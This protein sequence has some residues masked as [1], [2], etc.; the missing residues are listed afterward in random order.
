MLPGLMN[1]DCDSPAFVLY[2]AR[3]VVLLNL[4]EL[5]NK[6]SLKYGYRIELHAHTSP[7]SGCSEIS[8]KEMVDTYKALG[9]DAVVITNHFIYQHDKID[10]EAYMNAFVYDYDEAQI[11]GGQ[12]GLKIYLGAEIRFTENNNDYLIFGVNREMLLDIYDMLPFGV[13]NFRKNYPM[14]NSVFIQA[15]PKREGMK[16]IDSA[17]LDGI[18]IFNMHPSHNSKIGIASLYAKENHIS[19]VT[20]GSDFHHPQ[21]N[22]EGLAAMRT[23]Y[24]PKDSFELAKILKS[25]DYLLE[26]GRN[27]IIIP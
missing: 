15:H 17:F 1:N 25:R 18:E 9:Y 11:Y 19:V 20:A 5:K 8:P 4:Q 21:R 7:A 27:N 10:K 23:A 6:L 22:H 12:Q 13:E 14:P 2:Y 16:T 26:I 24:L 3:V